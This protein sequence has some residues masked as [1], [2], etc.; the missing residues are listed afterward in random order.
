[1]NILKNTAIAFFCLCSIPLVQADNYD[2]L[3]KATGWPV[4]VEHFD[5]ALQMMQN[6]YKDMLPP[7]FYQSVVG[8]SSQ[9]FEPTAM[10]Q[11]GLS[12]LK[13][14]L[15]SPDPALA[16]FD[17]ALGKKI[18]K[19]ETEATTAE[20]LQKN[21]QGVP[22]IKISNERKVLFKELAAAI[23]YRQA[24]VDVSTSLTSTMGDTVDSLFPGMGLGSSIKQITPTKAQIEQQV[25]AHLNDILVYVYR[26][27]TDQ[28]LQQFIAFAKSTEGKDYY[29]SAQKVIL[30]SLNK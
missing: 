24:T 18:V 29:Q 16:F 30:A 10:N 4:Q 6:Q 8:F 1:M 13:Q 12:A 28:E 26:D 22:V 2:E 17:S 25:D 3:Y 23:P 7:V 15:E 5:S 21:Q 9:R 20:N 14:S 19:A 27:L 11:R